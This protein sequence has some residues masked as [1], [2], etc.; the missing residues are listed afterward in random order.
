M[1]VPLSTLTHA[2]A[3]AGA[4]PQLTVSLETRGGSTVI[5]GDFPEASMC[6]HAFREA[7]TQ[8]PADGTRP[9]SVDAVRFD[10]AHE[11][12]PVLATGQVR[13]FVSDLAA[14]PTVST[15]RA[16]RP[17]GPRIDT[18]VRFDGELGLSVVRMESDVMTPDEL[19]EAAT[20][21]YAACLADHLIWEGTRVSR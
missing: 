5:V 10:G 20:H 3:L 12:G 11:R 21:A 17:D 7:V 8:W 14:Q 6:A 16:A 2:A 18:R 4:V 19:D 9:P 1:T 15:L 13:W